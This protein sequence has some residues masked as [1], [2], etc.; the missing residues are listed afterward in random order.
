M[1]KLK[2]EEDIPVAQATAV[3]PSN[4]AA[5]VVADSKSASTLT[6]IDLPAGV[7]SEGFQL[8]GS[9]VQLGESLDK[10]VKLPAGVD[11]RWFVHAIQIL[12]D[13]EVTHLTNA[14][15]ATK[16]LKSNAHLSRRLAVGCDRPVL[17]SNDG[18]YYTHSLPTPASLE[19]LQIK[20]NGFPPRVVSVGDTSAVAGKLHP[21]QVV[22]ELCIPG[23]SIINAQTPGFTAYKVEQEL[24]KASNVAGIRLTVK[25]ELRVI[26]KEK[27]SSAAF[28]DCVIL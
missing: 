16:I 1:D 17:N 23:Q 8:A 12:P 24:K 10:D 20:M 6:M 2:A 26:K 7:Q 4:T 21:R 5:L 18:F 28:D 9:P 11:A 19:A 14:E 15:T 22:A 3:A 27:G 13:L 25:D